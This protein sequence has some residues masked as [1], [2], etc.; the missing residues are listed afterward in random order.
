MSVLPRGKAAE[1]AQLDRSRRPPE[2]E[3]M[4]GLVSLIQAL[5]NSPNPQ[6]VQLQ[7]GCR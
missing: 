6:S 5:S 7:P 4:A 3:A 1:L 2:F